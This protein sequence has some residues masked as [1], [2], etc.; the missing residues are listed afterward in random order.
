MHRP[1]LR[2]SRLLWAAT[3]TLILVVLARASTALAQCP[4]AGGTA[5][6]P[7]TG[8]DLE[9]TTPYTVCAG[10]YHYGNVNVYGGGSLTFDD[11]AIDFWATSILIENQGSIIAGSPQQPIGTN[12][13][14][15]T[16]HL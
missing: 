7:G 11:A 16:F 15:V 6:P 2:S 5:L 9:V 13:G 14:I 3:S 10:T 1:R 4:P 12:G 8:E